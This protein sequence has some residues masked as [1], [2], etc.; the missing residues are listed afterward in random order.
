LNVKE[1]SSVTAMNLG[2]NFNGSLFDMV[3][4]A[5]F[6]VQL[7]LLLLLLFSVISWAIIL[8]KYFNIRKVKKEND[9][10][11]NVYMKGTKLSDIFPE[12]KKFRNSTLAEVFRSGYTELV[13]ITRAVRA[14]PTGREAAEAAGAVMEIG[15]IDNVER[16]MNRACGSETSKLEATLGFLATTGSASPFIG[17]FGTVWGIMDTF[18]GIGARGSATLAVVAPGISE[19]LIA[20]AAGLAAAIPAVIFYNYYLNQNKEL[21]L[22]M[23]NFASELLNIVERFYVKK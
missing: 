21:A 9:L 13:K 7:V 22:D 4:H 8:M 3:V 2:G 19:A 16:A 20:T 23:D 12:A 5:G 11:L 18:K 15:G 6:V 14:T 10:F 17:L 1:V